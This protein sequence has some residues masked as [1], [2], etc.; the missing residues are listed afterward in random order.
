MELLPVGPVV[1]IDTAGLDDTG[2]LGKLRIEKTYECCEM[3][4]AL[5]V[6]DVGPGSPRYN[7]IH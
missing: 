7:R 4:H 5:V 6:A 2:E 1:F 3:H